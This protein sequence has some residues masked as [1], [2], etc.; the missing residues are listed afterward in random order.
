MLLDPRDWSLASRIDEVL[1]A[2][3][4]ELA[5][6]AAAET[7]G[8][9]LEL[10]SRPHRTVAGAVAELESLRAGLAADLAPLELR[11]AVCGTHPFAQWSEVE[12][13]PG[14]RYRSIYDSMRELARREPTFALHVHVAVPD[15]RVGGARAARDAR[16]RPAAARAVGQL[17]VLAGPRH[18]PRLGA[19]AG[20]RHVPARRHP[21]RVR[22]LRR[23]RRGGRRAA[24]LRR[25]PRADVPV[26]G[27]AAAAE[28]RHDR[29]A[30]H[31]RADARRRQRRAGGAR[32]VRGAARGDG[33]LRRRGDRG[34]ARGARREPL[35]RHA[36]RDARGVH[37]P[38]AR[39][40]PAGAARSST[41]CSPRARRTPPSSAARPSS[42]PSRRSPPSPATTASGC[43]PASPRASQFGPA[44]GM[45]VSALAA[46]FSAAAR[47]AAPRSR[48]GSA[49]SP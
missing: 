32:A 35:P 31:G 8:S 39:H 20:L 45:L 48:A 2:L 19:R 36:R 40:A 16:A 30:D 1:P 44:L 22:Q 23:V 10:A 13:S 25:V 46:D 17:A 24:A 33:G 18:R 29:G 4:A 26:V 7:H 12:V 15:A 6:R 37:R 49:R 5:D 21:A 42:A 27:R 47:P 11:A 9:A 41:S 14:A 43:S 38:R 28:A 34:A 3:P